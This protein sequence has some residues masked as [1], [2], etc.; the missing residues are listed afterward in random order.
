[1]GL[2]PIF[3]FFLLVLVLGALYEMMP[4]YLCFRADSSCSLLLLNLLHK[5][6]H[7][8]RLVFLAPSVIGYRWN[9]TFLS[10]NVLSTATF[11]VL[12]GCSFFFGGIVL[13]PPQR[14][15]V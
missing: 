6:L 14:S 3:R 5:L 11:A 13:H 15:N 2:F 9:H 8:F 4:Y 10:P 7:L 12:G 1:L